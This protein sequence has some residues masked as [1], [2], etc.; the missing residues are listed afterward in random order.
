M[1]DTFQDTHMW[2]FI[3]ISAITMMI[4][5]RGAVTFAN[6]KKGSQYK[7]EPINR[8]NDAGG[9]TTVAYQ[10][11]GTFIVIQNNYQDMLPALHAMVVNNPTDTSIHLTSGG[12]QPNGATMTID[13]NY[14]TLQLR[15]LSVKISFSQS[16]FTPDLLINVSGIFSRELFEST[17]LPIFNQDDRYLS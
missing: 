8:K 6:L 5:T 2:K 9:E 10:F 17:T 12:N 3:P 11:S 13:L 7:L 15:D 1:A 16:D 14:A 4:P